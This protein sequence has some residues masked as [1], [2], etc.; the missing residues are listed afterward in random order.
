MYDV[1]CPSTELYSMVNYVVLSGITEI[2]HG[3]S[4]EL[5]AFKGR[6]DLKLTSSEMVKLILYGLLA[7]KIS[8]ITKLTL[9]IFQPFFFRLHFMSTTLGLSLSVQGQCCINQKDLVLL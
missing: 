7:F 1:S 2:W 5:D 9:E 3:I 8:H 6:L 4:L